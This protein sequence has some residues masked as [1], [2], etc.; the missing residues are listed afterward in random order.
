MTEH[1]PGEPQFGERPEP[2]EPEGDDGAAG[3]PAEP[4]GQ[5]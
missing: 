5:G 4:P 3:T 2:T 1:N